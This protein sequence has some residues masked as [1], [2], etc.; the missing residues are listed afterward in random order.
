MP[1]SAP[2][3]GQ[4][5]GPG[6]LGGDPRR[7]RS[8]A[9]AQA[10]LFTCAFASVLATVGIVAVLAIETLGFFAR[11]PVLDFVTGTRWAPAFQP[12]AF[13]ILPLMAGSLLV[14]AT[15]AVVALPTGLLVAIHLS[16]YAPSG[17]RRFLKPLVELLAGVPTVVYGYVALTVVTPALQR[18]L[19]GLQVYNALSAGLVIGVMIIP[20]VASLSETAL[21][22]VPR[23]WREAALS[24]GATRAQV[25]VRVVLPAA[26]SG[27]AAAF[28]LAV[29][30]ALAETM[31]VTIAA[32]AIPNLTANP[33]E[34]VQTMTAFI[35]QV[36]LGETPQGSVV[37]GSLF[38]VGMTLF[39]L[40]LLLNLV[41]Q[42][43]LG[44]VTPEPS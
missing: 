17:L 29:S 3:S 11:V 18:V 35:V 8:E 4:D 1:T 21:R 44:R 13:G 15:A 31:V 10:V 7:Q 23:G 28:I 34:A 39:L 19:P 16:E 42:W 36:S 5:P 14:A 22:A 9:I 27:V 33:L 25:V 20:T 40:T 6:A 2:S 32:G 12:P 24:L 30:R 41:S 43:V 26:G 37:H 38:A